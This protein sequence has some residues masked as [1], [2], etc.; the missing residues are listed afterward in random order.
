MTDAIVFHDMPDVDDYFRKH[1]PN[2]ARYF[3][4]HYSAVLHAKRQ[5]G[6][7]AVCLSDFLENADILQ[8]RDQVFT[9]V[10]RYVGVLDEV[11]GESLN[12]MFH[13][14]MVYFRPLYSYWGK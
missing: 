13:W 4:T 6:V 11:L 5:Y 1:E 14:K 2:H 3:C 8:L 7:E 10:E 12:R 9:D